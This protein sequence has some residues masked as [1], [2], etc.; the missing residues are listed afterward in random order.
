MSAEAAGPGPTCRV[1]G[2]TDRVGCPPAGCSWVTEDLCSAC[3]EIL[4][5]VRRGGAFNI[6]S[7]GNKAAMLLGAEIAIRA[8]RLRLYAG[9]R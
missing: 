6:A 5:K 9:A 2:C 4:E 3:H 7:R 1:C 8:Y